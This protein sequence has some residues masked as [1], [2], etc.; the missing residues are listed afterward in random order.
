MMARKITRKSIAYNGEPSSANSRFCM[1]RVRQRNLLRRKIGVANLNRKI[2][3]EI[4][5]HLHPKVSLAATFQADPRYRRPSQKAC[6]VR[7]LA[8]AISQPR[9]AE[10]RRSQRLLLKTILVATYRPLINS[11]HFGHDQIRLAFLMAASLV[12]D[13]WLIRNCT[14]G[15]RNE[16]GAV[17]VR[18]KNG[19]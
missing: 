2:S 9:K 14:G 7:P 15:A 12:R 8:V 13:Q 5:A 17:V 19:L 1:P 16:H 11:L 10:G 6:Q 3:R 18:R 4:C